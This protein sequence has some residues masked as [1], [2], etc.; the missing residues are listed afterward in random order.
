[1]YRQIYRSLADGSRVR[2]LQLAHKV[3]DPDSGTPRDQVLYH[4]GREDR[5]DRAQIQRLISDLG[6]LGGGFRSALG[7]NNGG[8]VVGYDT[9]TAGDRHAALWMLEV[10]PPTPVDAI[11]QVRR[12]VQNHRTVGSRNE[13][14]ADALLAKL[15]AATHQANRGNERAAV[16]LL[17]A[18]VN[19]VESF[20][21]AGTVSPSAG[22]S[23]IDAAQTAI[24]SLSQ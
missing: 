4:F 11:E 14:Q 15:D 5:I 10:A 13:G 18:F 23:L 2:Y 16:S 12:G 8:L 22:Q 6:T 17:E 19:Q 1:M 3:R 9:T 24:Q 21:N 20:V 7:I